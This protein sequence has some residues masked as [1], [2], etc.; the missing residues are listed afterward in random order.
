MKKNNHFD[1]YDIYSK[2]NLKNLIEVTLLIIYAIV[3]T[4]FLLNGDALFDFW[5]ENN[6]SYITL[7]YVA[8]VALFL[9]IREKLPKELEEEIPAISSGLFI[10]FITATVVC[11]ILRDAG[12]LF[13][14]IDG[15]IPVSSIIPLFVFHFVVVATSE[16]IIFRGVLFR[17]FYGFNPWIAIFLT[18]A[19]FAVFHVSAYQTNPS[20]LLPAFGMGLTLA[21]FV[22]RF[23]IGWAIGI[24]LAWNAFVLGI[25]T[26]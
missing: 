17:Y 23:N 19:L 3:V 25:T 8:C 5:R 24:H 7:I 6:Y 20:A 2:L 13:T 14:G 26:L 9:A 21:F 22:K 16:E 15:N 1:S 12:I 4:F 10:G 11:I 18:S